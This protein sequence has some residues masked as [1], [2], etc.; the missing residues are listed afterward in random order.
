MVLFTVQEK[1]Y[2]YGAFVEN[3]FGGK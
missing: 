1:C 3:L 2:G